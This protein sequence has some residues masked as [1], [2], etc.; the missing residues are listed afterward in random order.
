MGA[1]LACSVWLLG[2]DCLSDASDVGSPR[3]AIMRGMKPLAAGPRL[4]V[5]SFLVSGAVHLVRPQVFEPIVPRMLPGK[6]QVV[7]A[8]GAAELLC[9]VGLMIPQT[10]K[11]AGTASAALLVA[12]FPANM[13]MAIDAH[14]AV[15]HRGSTPLRRAVRAATIA[16]LPLQMPLVR[17]ALRS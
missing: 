10:R 16:R 15:E 6:R 3:P 7:Y 17:W 9:A 1:S 2:Q 11:C 4:V 13:Q 14:R 5:G 8:S 12:V